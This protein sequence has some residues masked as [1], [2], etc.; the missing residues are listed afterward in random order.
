M[1]GIYF[2]MAIVIFSPLAW[3]YDGW[4]TGK[5]YQVRIQGSRVLIN[6]VGAQNPGDCTNTDYLY[7]PQGETAYHKNMFSAVLTAYAA[8]KDVMLALN[9]CVNGYPLISEVWVK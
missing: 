8:N 9:G 1:K 4:S 2:L 3:A 6:Q 7:L 5:I